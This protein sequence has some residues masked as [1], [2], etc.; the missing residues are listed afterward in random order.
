MADL[1]RFPG[2]ERVKE[3]EVIVM[4]P[5]SPALF[6]AANSA[7]RLTLTVCKQAGLREKAHGAYSH[8]PGVDVSIN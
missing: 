8:S 4:S 1:D 5:D 2:Q 3:K 7:P 6:V